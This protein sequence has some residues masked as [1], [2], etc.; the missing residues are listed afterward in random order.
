MRTTSISGRARRIT[1]PAAA[2]LI[3]TGACRRDEREAPLPPRAEVLKDVP[4]LSFARLA[5][6]TGAE[7]AERRT[8]LTLLP[9]DTVGTFYRDT[10]PKLG[11]SIMSDQGDSARLDMLSTKGGLSLWVHAETE[12]VQGIRRTRFTLIGSSTGLVIDAGLPRPD[13]GR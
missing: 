2:L 12:V 11:W 6:T 1:A 5:D 8:Y 13:S 7:D 10:L 9:F 4:A 3:L